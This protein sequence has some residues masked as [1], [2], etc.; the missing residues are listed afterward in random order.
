[1]KN[2]NSGPPS[3]ILENLMATPLGLSVLTLV[4]S[5]MRMENTTMA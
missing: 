1:M 4:M 2:P 3:A 5:S